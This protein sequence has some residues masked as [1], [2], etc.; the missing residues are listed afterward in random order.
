MTVINY[1]TKVI[2]YNTN[3]INYKTKVILIYKGNKL[4]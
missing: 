2:N 1:N 4:Q 3:V